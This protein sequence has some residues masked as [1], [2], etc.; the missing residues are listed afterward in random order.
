MGGRGSSL[1][2]FQRED[3]STAYTP[4]GHRA[5]P[6]QATPLQTAHS[7]AV[8]VPNHLEAEHPQT[9][10]RRLNDP[11]PCVGSGGP[12]G[13]NGFHDNT[14]ASLSFFLTSSQEFSRGYRK[15]DH[16]VTVTVNRI[17]A[18]IFLCFKCFLHCNFPCR[19]C[20]EMK[21][22]LT[23]SRGVGPRGGTCLPAEGRAGSLQGLPLLN[24]APSLRRLL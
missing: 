18:S 23:Q 9:S 24:D 13:P 19:K 7:P 3:T 6:I 2:C 10:P 16:T 14:E 4:S 17:Y 12:R 8:R 20:Q 22:T 21:P 15:C 11:P 1:L 5:V